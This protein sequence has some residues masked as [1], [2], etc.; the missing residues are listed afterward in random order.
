MK[1]ILPAFVLLLMLSS[2][3][4]YQY[5]TLNA[6]K[7]SKD[8]NRNVI[9]DNDSLHIIYHFSRPA[10][11]DI[12]IHNKTAAPMYVDWKKS[13]I[14]VAE[15]SV[16][17]YDTEVNVSGDVVQNKYYSKPSEPTSTF[18]G[19]FNIPAGTD[20][21]PPQTFFTK[22]QIDVSAVLTNLQKLSENIPVQKI[23]DSYGNRFSY[24][25]SRYD[26]TSSPLK[27]RIYLTFGI[28]SDN[29]EFAVEHVFYIAELIETSNGLQ[30]IFIKENDGDKV[31]NRVGSL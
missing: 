15:R 22:S 18:N 13:A 10:K 5:I 19:T 24:R 14:I 23:T 21:M 7:T 31:Y 4:S 16:S 3:S 2:C 27:F 12:S 25:S 8:N 29:K 6:E 28:G 17:L 1:P 11:F 20:F 26:C 9:W 30:G